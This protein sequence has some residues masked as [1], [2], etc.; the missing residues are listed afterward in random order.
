M[1]LSIIYPVLNQ[2]PLAQAAVDSAI[3]N[4]S[5]EHEVEI[6]ILDNNSD[7][8]ITSPF[9]SPQFLPSK[10]QKVIRYNKN[11]GVYPTFWEALK[12]T[13]TDIIAYL[14]SDLIICEKG[15]DK[16]LLKAFEDDP[17]LGLVGFIGSSEI[18]SA[19]GR[20]YGTTSNF[21]GKAHIR[22]NL[23]KVSKLVWNGSH[24][25]IHG[26]MSDGLSPAKVV[27]G[28]AMVF[29]R[30]VLE[31]IPERKDFPPHHFYDRLLSCEVIELGYKVAVLGIA[32]DHISNATVSHEQKYWDMAEAWARAHGLVPVL[33][34]LKFDTSAV[35]PNWDMALYKEAER[36]W[37]SEY[38]DIKH[39]IPCKI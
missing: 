34:G 28:C 1:K 32:C 33:E 26:R 27:D 12:Y 2:F 3:Q 8:V 16:R 30:S 4:L 25:R 19:G 23:L 14:H 29:R 35:K 7:I 24:A 38:R 9:I 22:G 5:G 6:V 31:Q 13:D 15:W 11:I 20:G 21:Q 17:K 37:L 18:D 10:R 39:F 36:Q